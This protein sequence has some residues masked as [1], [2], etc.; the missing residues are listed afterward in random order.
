MTLGQDKITNDHVTFNICNATE[1]CCGIITAISES[2]IF[3]LTV[4]LPALT[5]LP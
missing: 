2:A 3:F 4:F 1:F 5:T